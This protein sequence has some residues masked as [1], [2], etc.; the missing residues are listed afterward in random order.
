M[1]GCNQIS[2]MK[3][4][5]RISGLSDAGSIA[6]G[7]LPVL[8]GYLLANVVQKQFLSGSSYANIVKLGG[9]IILA[10]M[11]KG[12]ISQL[13]VG[14]ALNGAVDIAKPALESAGLGLLPPGDPSRY[15]AG[16]PYDG[17]SVVV[18]GQPLGF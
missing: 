2:G 11:T 18:P 13:G 4:R 8:G 10:S 7:I 6:T 16:V 14:M 9:G 12:M 5:K 15:I 3:R 17:G 1:C